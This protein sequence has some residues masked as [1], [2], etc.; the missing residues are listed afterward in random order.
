MIGSWC[1]APSN[2]QHGVWTVSILYTCSCSCIHFS[3]W[4]NFMSW[5]LLSEVQELPKCKTRKWLRSMVPECGSRS[6]L[7]QDCCEDAAF[8]ISVFP[9]SYFCKHFPILRT[10]QVCEGV[11]SFCGAQ[12]SFVTLL[13]QVRQPLVSMGYVLGPM[14]LVILSPSP[15]AF[16][17]HSAFPGEFGFDQAGAGATYLGRTEKQ[18]STR[19]CCSQ[20]CMPQR[21][22]DVGKSRHRIA[23]GALLPPQGL[24]C[25]LSLCMEFPLQCG[26]K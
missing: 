13:G 7:V 22:A 19:G 26:C 4:R 23:S 18:M 2:I 12:G 9:V 20:M 17:I 3:C 11:T 24:A 21:S 10:K 25:P 5:A 15:S 6:S 8:L 16:A 1:W 14:H